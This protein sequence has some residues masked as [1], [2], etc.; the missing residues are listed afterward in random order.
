MIRFRHR[1][2][3]TTGEIVKY[4]GLDNDKIQANDI[5]RLG[6]MMLE[7]ILARYPESYLENVLRKS[8]NRVIQKKKD[9]QKNKRG[10]EC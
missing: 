2:E 9:Y 8:L 5:L 6:S 1:I 7:P 10:S 4:M 3:P